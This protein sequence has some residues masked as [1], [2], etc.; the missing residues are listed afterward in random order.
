MFGLVERGI[1]DVLGGRDLLAPLLGFRLVL[2][3]GFLDRLTIEDGFE[4]SSVSA[5]RGR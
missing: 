4:G 2:I 3:E 1:G 5:V